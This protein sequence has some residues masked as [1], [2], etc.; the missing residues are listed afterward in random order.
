METIR[1]K[2]CF[3]K[4]LSHRNGLAPFYAKESDNPEIVY[5]TGGNENGNYGNFACDFA[6]VN[7]ISKTNPNTGLDEME[8]VEL[9]RLRYTDIIRNYNRLKEIFKNSVIVK[10]VKYTETVVDFYDC[11]NDRYSTTDMEGTKWVDKFQEDV[12]MFECKAIDGKYFCYDAEKGY[13]VNGLFAEIRN[14]VQN[15]L[16]NG[17]T[18]DENSMEIYDKVNEIHGI[19]ADD[20]VTFGVLIS[21]YDFLLKCNEEWERWWS[22][23]WRQSTYSSYYD[24][25]E[26]YVFDYDYD[27]TLTSLNPFKF[28]MDV[29]TY[30]LGRIYV[31][32]EYNGNKIEGRFVPEV[33]TTLTFNNYRQWFNENEA[34]SFSNPQLRKEWDERGGDAFFEFLSSITPKFMHEMQEPTHGKEVYFTYAVPNVEISLQMIDEYMY[35]TEYS[36]YEYSV[37]INGD[38][39]DGTH[40]YVPPTSGIG[41]GLTPSFREY[42]AGEIRCESKLGYVCNDN[43]FWVSDEI[44]GVFSEFTNWCC[45]FECTFYS[46][47]SSSPQIRRVTEKIEYIYD[48]ANGEMVS[49]GTKGPEIIENYIYQEETK[50]LVN[51]ANVYQVVGIKTTATTMDDVFV[52]SSTTYEWINDTNHLA[53]E[54]VHYDYYTEHAY[55]WWECKKVQNNYGEWDQYTCS[56]GEYLTLA[57]ATGRTYKNVL[58]LSCMPYFVN[59]EEYGWHCYFMAKYDNG[60]VNRSQGEPIDEIRT[61]RALDIPYIVGVPM[62]EQS[63]GGEWSGTVIFDSVVSREVDDGII[64]IK[65]VIGKTSGASHDTGIIY[66]ERYRYEENRCETVLIDGLYE[67]EI[68]YNKLFKEE[69]TEVHSEDY[70]IKRKTHI[71]DIIGMEIGTQWTSASCVDAALITEE[72]TEGLID[73]PNVEVSLSFDRGAA[74]GWEHHFKLSECNT[75]EDL[76]NYGNGTFFKS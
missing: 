67:G 42:E 71:A 25:W 23:G 17:E 14:A 65:Y 66:S 50:P 22:D 43:C 69:G 70:N 72:A 74:A 61:V 40:E 52:S 75:L 3:D 26:N 44:S 9:S 53:A 16:D 2:I 41:S 12:P 59:E 1:K 8:K 38:I 47:I 27:S 37:N 32:E 20:N 7:A 10:K 36:P 63:L 13:T 62:N 15:Q 28:F 6:L 24:R 31:P 73:T 60:N 18:V 35:E 39:V 29:E 11:V 56:D 54:Y 30:M 33:V 5:V 49:A 58:I 48:Y 64:N 55:T 21:D 34:A 46:G 4:A 45:L 76:E 68:Y 19:E 51:G 57:Q